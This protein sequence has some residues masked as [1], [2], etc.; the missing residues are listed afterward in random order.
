MESSDESDEA[1]AHHEDDSRADLETGGIIGIESEHVASVAGAYYGVTTTTAAGGGGGTTEPASAHASCGGGGST[2]CGGPRTG[3]GG[4]G[5]LGRRA[6]RHY[7][8]VGLS[9]RW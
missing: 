8:G 6:S 4:G 2:G 9:R 3:G 1:E 5:G 7:L